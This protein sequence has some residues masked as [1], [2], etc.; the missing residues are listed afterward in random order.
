LSGDWLGVNSGFDQG[1]VRVTTASAP[2]KTILFGEHAVV[3]GR[4][5][6]AVPVSDLRATAQVEDGPAGG[7]VLLVAEDLGETY[8]LDETYD[9]DTARA[10]QVTV[11]NTLQF[12][13]I[14]SEEQS[15]V[16]RVS[17][18]IPIARGL[19]SGA[20]IATALVR[21]LARH[22]G[23]FITA[24]AISDLTYQTEIVF[25]GTPSGIDNTV[26]AFEKPVYFVKGER[27]DIFWVGRPFTLL[28]ADTGVPSRTRDTV[29]DVRQQWQADRLRY[30]A[31]FDGVGQIVDAARQAIAV[32][33]VDALGALMDENQAILRELGVSSPEL[34][35][36]IEVAREAGAKGAKLSG[37][38]RGGCLI[39]LANGENDSKIAT[40]L[41]L[42][43]AAQ[44]ISTVVH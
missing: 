3:Y 40:A 38:G 8:R 26:V 30:E 1:G 7:G 25:H 44:V 28:V 13:D 39:A 23:R 14:S 21:A 24:S 42:A 15:L 37:G 41:L 4:P 11:R 43:G 27:M 16:V 2:G 5:A 9:S 22:Y 10:L 12:L 20:A 6:I 17:S 36:L 19:G 31:L 32:G 34:D 33:D 29:A 18:Q 35:R